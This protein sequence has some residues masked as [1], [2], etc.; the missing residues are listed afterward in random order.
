MYKFLVKVK[1]LSEI[2]QTWL[3][4]LLWFD[5]FS[6][7]KNNYISENVGRKNDVFTKCSRKNN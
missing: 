4:Y 2:R 5:M 1:Y 3:I 7:M 6:T